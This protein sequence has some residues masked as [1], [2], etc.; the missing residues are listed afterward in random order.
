[1]GADTADHRHSGFSVSNDSLLSGHSAYWRR[2]ITN[3]CIHVSNK[4]RFISPRNLLS[5]YQSHQDGRHWAEREY[6]IVNISDKGKS[7]LV[8]LEGGHILEAYLDQNGIPT[9]GVGMTFYPSNNQKVKLG[10]KI[11]LVESTIAFDMMLR[12]FVIALDSLTNDTIN[13]NQF[14]ALTSFIYNIGIQAY[15]DSR[16]REWINQQPNQERI[17]REFF[18]WKRTGG[19]ISDGLIWRRHV[20]AN[21][22]CGRV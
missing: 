8:K 12:H 16:I 9:I 17:E 3:S 7:F 10:D 11:T 19:I 2:S 18:R 20:E 6:S 14:D 13:Q 4:R 1:M 5:A 15:K 21:L 22:Y